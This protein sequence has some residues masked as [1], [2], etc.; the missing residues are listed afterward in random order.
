MT[1]PKNDPAVIARADPAD[2][3]F[4]LDF[5]LRNPRSEGKDTQKNTRYVATGFLKADLQDA[6]PVGSVGLV[7]VESKKETARAFLLVEHIPIDRTQEQVIA[8]WRQFATEQGDKFA[9]HVGVPALV[10]WASGRSA[11]IGGE[12]FETVEKYITSQSIEPPGIEVAGDVDRK[13]FLDFVD[14]QYGLVSEDKSEFRPLRRI[15]PALHAI[16]G[17]IPAGGIEITTDSFAFVGE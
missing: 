1:A 4:I 10:D 13:K 5:T 12:K 15:S 8:A 2:N 16:F 17:F 14:D 6:G 7:I 9:D 3:D 11:T